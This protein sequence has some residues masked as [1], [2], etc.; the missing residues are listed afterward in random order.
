[1]K[2]D[3][4][5]IIYDNCNTLSV[6][7]LIRAGCFAGGATDFATS[8]EADGRPCRTLLQIK[9]DEDGLFIK[10]YHASEAV[11][12]SY[13]IH[14]IAV[15][16]G[17]GNSSLW[18]FECPVTGTHC[19]KLWFHNGYLQHRS[20]IKGLYQVQTHTAS[21]QKFMGDVKAVQA[22]SKISEKVNGRFFRKTYASAPA[23]SYVK[24]RRQ[25]RKYEQAVCT[26]HS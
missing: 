3:H 14:L 7:E 9:A 26:V 4:H 21:I 5:S 18:Y 1:M 6:Y 16:S 10:A 2:N 20:A 11:Q 24:M 17:L 15:P 12:V 13:N 25:L 19:R 23:K 22:L 8:W